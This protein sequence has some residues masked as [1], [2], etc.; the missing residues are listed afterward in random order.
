MS[1]HESTND[2]EVQGTQLSRILVTKKA[3]VAVYG[4][5]LSIDLVLSALQEQLPSPHAYKLGRSVLI[6]VWLINTIIS[7][8]LGKEYL[9][10]NAGNI[11]VTFIVV[12]LFLNTVLSTVIDG[13]SIIMAAFL[14][15]Y[16]CPEMLRGLTERAAMIGT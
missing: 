1:N 15:G 16:V 2:V 6:A 3:V 5:V 11:T 12:A 8:L 10:Q 14:A 7:F 13:V 9:K 4:L